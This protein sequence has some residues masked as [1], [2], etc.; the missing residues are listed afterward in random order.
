MSI[1]P[2]VKLTDWNAQTRAVVLEVDQLFPGLTWGTYN[3]HDPH[4][5]RAGDGM[6]PGY[7]TAAGIAKG[8]AVAAWLW[9]NR[10]RYN[11]W[12]VI[13]R[14]RII[15]MTYESSGWRRYF[16]ADD[17]S[18]SKSHR[19]HPHFSTYTEPAKPYGTV[20]LDRLLP[21]VSD[22]ESVRIVQRALGCPVTGNYDDATLS[23]ARVFQRVTLQ[24]AP[25]F[26]TGVLGKW[27]TT[28]LMRRSGAW[29]TLRLDSS[30]EPAP[31]K[32]PEA[33]D[34]SAPEPA[35]PVVIEPDPEAIPEAARA[36]A[37]KTLANVDLAAEA[38]A[39]AGCPWWLLCAVLEK[40]SRGQNIYGHDKGG[41]LSDPDG[42]DIPVTEDNWATF[43][44]L[45][46]VQGK[47]S[48]GVGPMQIT[49]RGFF[50]EMEAR[51]LKPWD[52][53]DNLRYGAELLAKYW[54]SAEG[55][56]DARVRR[57]GR[58]YNGAD[59]YGDSLVPVAAAWRAKLDGTAPEPEPAPV[60]LY[61][62]P[63]SGEVYLDRLQPGVVGSDSVAYAQVWLAKVLGQ[64]VARTGAYDDATQ[65]AVKAYQ[66]DVLGD[67]P[68]HADGALGKLQT[69]ALA[70]AA[71]AEV[72]IYAD[73]KEGGQVWP[74]P[75]VPP[76]PEPEP[77]PDGPVIVR[78]VSVNVQDYNL[79]SSQD[80]PWP[81]RRAALFA[82]VKSTRPDVAIIQEA[83]EGQ[84]RELCAALGSTWKAAE[85]GPG[86]RYGPLA[87]AYN[88]A[89]LTPGKLRGKTLPSNRYA[90]AL[91]LTIGGK[92]FSAICAHLDN[93]GGQDRGALRIE[94]AEALTEWLPGEVTKD[95][96]SPVIF[97]ADLND[98][99]TGSTG[100]RAVMRRAGMTFVRDIP[101][102]SVSGR[103]YESHHGYGTLSKTGAWIDDL[104]VRGVKRVRSA[105]L[106]RTDKAAPTKAHRNGT[107]HC[108]VFAEV[109]L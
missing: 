87:I 16:A 66:R 15:S 53:A 108:L 62:V 44:D 106:V 72:T 40:E 78:A 43:R 47:T 10:K 39:Q 45:V 81:P 109:E 61:P 103:E 36:V 8:D 32:V 7:K 58:L 69:I 98:S 86:G 57:V 3:G 31:P 60:P 35:P 80:D 42:K 13:W 28:E 48:N 84:V 14:G 79:A 71:D 27:Q 92:M 51:G 26:S 97:A 67:S 96:A 95:E 83:T 90:M 24:D 75:E 63:D 33:P 94:Q 22:S 34:V 2:D 50:T 5:S 76:T 30:G 6:V 102:L 52:P 65:G 89:K 55:T 25:E 105:G 91:E 101:W 64:D 77:T 49:W 11:I 88:A 37:R 29:A 82:A 38:A 54:N 18:D 68:E 17:P 12:Y 1:H 41:A 74:E 20:F 85:S 99:R 104:A 21:G 4:K 93:N 19:N 73:S 100:P 46:L 56:T 9:A 70:Q 23:A 107:D 59:A